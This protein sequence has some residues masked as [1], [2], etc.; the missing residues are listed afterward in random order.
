MHNSTVAVDCQSC[1]GGDADRQVDIDQEHTY[2]AE[3]DATTTGIYVV[4]DQDVSLHLD[5]CFNAQEDE[6]DQGQIDQVHVG[7]RPRIPRKQQ[8]VENERIAGDTDG[9]DESEDDDGYPELGRVLLPNVLVI[10][11]RGVVEYGGLVEAGIDGGRGVVH[12]E[13]GWRNVRIDVSRW[14]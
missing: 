13:K 2:L 4:M 1:Q 14:R 12:V 6:I 8:D 5:R 3:N 7:H 10:R 9:E 11:R